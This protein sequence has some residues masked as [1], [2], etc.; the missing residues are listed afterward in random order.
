MQAIDI[1]FI[2]LI[3][4]MVA[5]GLIKGF[6]RELFSWAAL[7][8]SIWVAVLLF[9]AGGAFIRSM[10]MENV[11]VVPELL[12]FVAIFLIIMIVVKLLERIL[13]D[14]VEGANLGAVNKFLGGIFGLV[15][16]FAITLLVLF[17]LSVQPLFDASALVGES[18]FGQF[19]LPF[20]RFLPDRGQEL[21]NIV[22]IVFPAWGEKSV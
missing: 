14:V 6:I 22:H 4:L 8:L 2:V 9:P 1:F 12:A 13:R 16:G 11:R 5:H 15:E 17:V 19:L 20:F 10:I 21:V 3:L 7:V 18:F